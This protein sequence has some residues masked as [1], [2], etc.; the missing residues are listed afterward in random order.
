MAWTPTQKALVTVGIANALLALHH[1]N[2]NGGKGL[3]QGNLKPS[4]ILLDSDLNIHITDY[5]SYALEHSYLTYSCQVATPN[6]T[7]PES[8]DLDDEDFNHNN[9]RYVR[10]RQK[11]DIFSFGLIMYEILTGEEVFSSELSAAD[12]R[13]KTL[14]MERPGIPGNVKRE[15]AKLIE[16]CWDKEPSQR[17]LAGTVWQ[18]LN[19][20]NFEI[21]VDTDGVGVDGRVVR[22]RYPE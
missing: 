5:I 3:F 13:R 7:A 12:L 15:A 9:Q 1:S 4:D 2:L 6:Y 19:S 11:V 21:V 8:Y 18:K 10:K 20:I 14:S 22:A 17:P 16:Q